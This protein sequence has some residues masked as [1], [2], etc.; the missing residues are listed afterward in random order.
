MK[1]PFGRNGCL[2]SI[3]ATSRRGIDHETTDRI[4]LDH[5]LRN[6]N[7][8][9]RGAIN[10]HNHNHN[11]HDRIH[12]RHDNDDNDNNDHNHDND[13]HN[14]HHRSNGTGALS[15]VGTAGRL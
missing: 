5:R 11:R 15:I 10:R 2:T 14:D 4:L 3:N 8:R 1:R 12:N 9:M 13:N 7:V 6:D